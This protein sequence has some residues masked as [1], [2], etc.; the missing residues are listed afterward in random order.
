MTPSSTTASSGLTTSTPSR[1]HLTSVFH[2][3]EALEPDL[4]KQ[5]TDVL[6]AFSDG[7]EFYH[8]SDLL[9]NAD[10]CCMDLR[11]V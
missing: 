2:V 10:I 6:K 7:K 4:K 8:K 11:D 5:L 9:G 1:T 3:N